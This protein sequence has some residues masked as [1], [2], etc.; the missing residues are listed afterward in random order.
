MGAERRPPTR[1][2]VVR[3]GDVYTL[4]QA[5]Y[6]YGR[7]DIRL[8]DTA[9]PANAEL[10][11]LEWVHLRD[12]EQRRD[13]TEGPEHYYLCRVQALR[14]TLPERPGPGHG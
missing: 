6:C 9:V 8:R 11:A 14:E 12:P 1:W 13:G 5:D 2:P 3:V 7:G 4:D 10:L